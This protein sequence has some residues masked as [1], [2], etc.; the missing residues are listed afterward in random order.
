MADPSLIKQIGDELGRIFRHMMPGLSALLAARLSHPS[1]FRNIDYGNTWHLV[2]LAIIATVAGNT[3]YVFHRY[4]V[5][6]AIDLVLYWFRVEKKDKEGSYLNW[7]ATHI[8]K[9]FHFLPKDRDLREHINLRSA[10]IIFMFITCEILFAFSFCAE[11]PS[12]FHQFRCLIR[13][14]TLCALVPVILQHIIGFVIDLRF[15]TIH[16]GKSDDKAPQAEV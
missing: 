3:L 10:Q 4:S 6:Q 12:V 1:W 11:D 8:D 15:T 7:L 14:V 2:L 16:G 9:S 13:W 5:H